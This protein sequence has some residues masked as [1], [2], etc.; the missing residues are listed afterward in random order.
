M[1]TVVHKTSRSNS[2]ILNDETG[3]SKKVQQIQL[4]GHENKVHFNFAFIVFYTF[5]FVLDDLNTLID[6]FNIADDLFCHFF[7]HSTIYVN[8]LYSINK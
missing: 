7:F 6:I 2:H 4:Y 3:E 1:T 8:V 5:F